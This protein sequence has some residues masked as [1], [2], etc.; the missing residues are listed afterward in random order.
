M[1]SGDPFG[2]VFEFAH[3]RSRGNASE[4]KSGLNGSVLHEC[5]EGSHF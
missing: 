4:V 3:V 2:E 5:S 1:A